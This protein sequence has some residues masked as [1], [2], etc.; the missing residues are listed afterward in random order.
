MTF[1]YR[2]RR[3]ETRWIPGDAA[4]PTLVL[5]HE[6]LGS[7]SLWRDFPDRLAAATGAPVLV[8]SRLGYGR[9]D[10]AP[11]PFDMDFMH[12]E[13]LEVLPAVLDHFGIAEPILVGHSDGG[14]IALIHAGKSGRPV[15]ALM[16]EAPHV[17]VE[18]ETLVGIRAA[19]QVW[20]TTDLR[21]RLGRHHT[22]PE[23]TFSLW[24]DIW[25]DP[26]FPQWN[27]EDVLPGITAPTLLIQGEE[28]EYGTPAQVKAVA[29]QVSGPAELLL[30]PNCKH[31]PHRD[32]LEAVL[33]AMADFVKRVAAEAAAARA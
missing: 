21:E 15:K 9:S 7:V 20:A 30:L 17:F 26:R 12:R 5:L 24:R 28:D 27:I 33:G 4:A 22:D 18:E 10:P 16:L 2:N 1:T 13:A 3:L 29:A 32:Q 19:D 11:E 31:S 25:L 8:Y 14:S 23:H 6:G